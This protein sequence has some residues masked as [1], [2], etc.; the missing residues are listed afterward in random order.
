MNESQHPLKSSTEEIVNDSIEVSVFNFP[1]TVS[2]LM[3]IFDLLIHNYMVSHHNLDTKRMQR[4]NLLKAKDML[5][6]LRKH[7]NAPSFLQSI[8]SHRE[9]L[10]LI[11]VLASL[12][13]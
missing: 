9:S 8:M 2:Q 4:A 12:L 11:N 6:T 3:T 7:P 5:L 13:F 10:M 1:I